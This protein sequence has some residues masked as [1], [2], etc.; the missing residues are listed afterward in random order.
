MLFR[1]PLPQQAAFDSD[2]HG[3]HT[4]GILAGRAMGK[5][6]FGAAPGVELACAVVIEGGHTIARVLGGLDWAVDQQVR[7]LNLSLGLRGYR[8]DFLPIIRLLR[9]R[10][11]LP[12][13]AAGNEGPGTSRSPGNYPEVLSVGACAESDEVADFSSSDRFL[14]TDDPISPDLVAPGEGIFSCM[15]R[16]GHEKSSGTSMAAPH[17]AGLASLLIEAFPQAN[18]DQLERAIFESCVRPATMQEERANRGVPDGPRALASL[19][20]LLG[21][22]PP[23]APARRSTR[24]RQ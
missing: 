18:V 4:A 8:A 9:I 2:S 16:R 5:M 22:K 15:P 6:R 10:G 12:V 13:V 3:T 14:R 1:S 19:A 23:A 24:R 11:V 17:V 20:A 7:V 21:Q